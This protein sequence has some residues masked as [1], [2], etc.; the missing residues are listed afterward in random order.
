MPEKVDLSKELK[1]V[2]RA[3]SKV[4]A[5]ITVPR[6]KY[7]MIDGAGYPETS[8]DFHPA[9]EAL[10]SI[11][12]TI[13]FMFK[14]GPQQLDFKIMPLEGIWWMKDDAQWDMKR[15]DDWRWRLASAVPDFVDAAALRE[16]KKQI[17]KKKD[18][19]S[20]DKLRLKSWK[21]GDA[22]QMMH[23]GPYDK[24][25]AA[26]D[27]ILAFTADNG[28]AVNGRHHEIYFSDPRRVAPEKLK[29]IIRFPVKKRK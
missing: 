7:L 8:P 3:S 12:Y 16:A 2:Y 23:I 10:F 6:L 24:E 27:S 21:E 22:V 19:P 17:K 28:Y 25:Q 29:T 4:P 15:P 1:A 18:L 13:K 5:L 20:A 9:M 26:I 14:K 11:A